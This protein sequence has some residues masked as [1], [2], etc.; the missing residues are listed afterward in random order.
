M[1]NEINLPLFKVR[2][3]HIVQGP[4]S[5]R[6]L[7]K[8]IQQYQQHLGTG[9]TAAFSSKCF[10]KTVTGQE[11]FGAQTWEAFGKK[12]SLLS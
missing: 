8:L 7:N 3:V 2:T 6:R 1:H 5:G 10:G 11:E 4:L 9:L 12:T